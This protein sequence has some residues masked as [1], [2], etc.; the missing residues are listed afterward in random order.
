M[1]AF[2]TGTWMT[3]S[4]F[5]PGLASLSHSTTSIWHEATEA[6]RVGGWR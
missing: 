6:K 5:R 4:Y 3:K 2:E 1:D